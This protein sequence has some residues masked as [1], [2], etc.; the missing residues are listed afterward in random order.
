MEL[1]VGARNGGLVEI[2]GPLSSEA[3]GRFLAVSGVVLE[4]GQEV[5]LCLEAPA[6]M[7]RAVGMIGRGYVVVIDYGHEARDL[8]H[9]GRR[10]GTLLAYHRHRVNE[11]F[12]RR[13]GDQDLTA[14]V[15][16][17]ALRRSVERSGGRCLGL[18]T[19]TRFLLALGVLD[20]LPD[21]DGRAD[22]D[23]ATRALSVTARLREREALKDLFLPDRMGES[24]RVLVAAKGDVGDTLSGLAEPWARPTAGSASAIGPLAESRP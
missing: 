6:W 15:D 12:L 4:A 3:L 22:Q 14:H 8:Y 17:S 21:I 5:D 2:A 19:Q 9:P 11:E 24:F 13:P 23:D 1:F 18:I 7:E 16:F 20:L 10:R